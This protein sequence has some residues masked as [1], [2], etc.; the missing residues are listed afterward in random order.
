[1][2]IKEIKA[3]VG[4]AIPTGVKTAL[5]KGAI[6]IL[7]AFK[8]LIEG[9]FGINIS[10]RIQEDPTFVDEMTEKLKESTA[11]LLKSL[12]GK[13]KLTPESM[14][15]NSLIAVNK[16]FISQ[17]EKMKINVKDG[18]FSEEFKKDL[19]EEFENSIEDIAISIR[20]TDE[21]L[22]ED[23]NFSAEDMASLKEKI[24]IAYGSPKEGEPMI[25]FSGALSSKILNSLKGIGHLHRQT[26]DDT[27]IGNLDLDT[28]RLAIKN[29][30]EFDVPDHIIAMAQGA[31]ERKALDAIVDTRVNM[32]VLSDKPPSELIEYCEKEGI[33]LDQILDDPESP[34]FTWYVKL[35]ERLAQDIL[36]NKEFKLTPKEIADSKSDLD[37][38][39][40]YEKNLLAENKRSNELRQADWR[41]PKR[42]K[43]GE[44]LGQD[45]EYVQG[46]EPGN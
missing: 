33:T 5:P 42:G 32:M 13:D 46:M 29:L 17:S 27:L 21:V 34:H 4:N 37:H 26:H 43:N 15:V 25:A 6:S 44:Q 23:L 14:V 45:S 16:T 19:L 22:F 24:S 39:K 10:S 12:E 35:T 2:N 41:Q 28:A 8:N 38:Y 18:T 20:N 9:A 36:S 40:V 3:S 7:L 1:M 30:K 11:N 31:G